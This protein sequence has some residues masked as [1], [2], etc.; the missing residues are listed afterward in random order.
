M[1]REQILDMLD[2]GA[3]SADDAA[4][5]LE[6][7]SGPHI[8]S[9]HDPL[10]VQ[11]HGELVEPDQ[12]VSTRTAPDTARWDRLRQI[13]FA[14]AVAILILSAWGLYALFPGPESGITFGWVLVLLVFVLSVLATVITF[15]LLNAP[16]LH[17]R[18]QEP[19]GRRIAISFPIPLVIA[20]WGIAIARR[21]VDDQ[22]TGYLDMSAEFLRAL[23][24]DDRQEREPIQI[25]VDDDG[26]R[27]QIFIG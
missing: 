21:F 12:V 17:L 18:I 19:D 9:P 3:I 8:E 14:V 15:S 27:V 26:Q 23:R 1:S 20:N 5:L 22:T 6:A 16:W 4:R 11:D 2:R 25:D 7:I 13:P 24:K 10:D